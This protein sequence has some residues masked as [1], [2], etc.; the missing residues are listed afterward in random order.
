MFSIQYLIFKNTEI[1]KGEDVSIIELYNPLFKLEKERNRK[2]NIIITP[3]VPNVIPIVFTLEENVLAINKLSLTYFIFFTF[4][5][6]PKKKSDKLNI[7]PLN[8]YNK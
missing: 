8:T 5:I 2:V 1:S 7:I 3:R 4:N 6:I